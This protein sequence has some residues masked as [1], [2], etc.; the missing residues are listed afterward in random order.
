MSNCRTGCPTQDHA[1]WGECARGMNLQIGD[2]GRGVTAYTD[3]RLQTYADA[4]RQGLQP[5]STL[6]SQ[7]LKT[8]RNAGA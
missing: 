6:L 3:R 5:K 4:R 2:L 8:L 1:T 7:S